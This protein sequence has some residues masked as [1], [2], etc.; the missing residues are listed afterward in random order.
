MVD[1]KFN[2]MSGCLSRKSKKAGKE[3]VKYLKK[4]FN[5]SV[6]IYSGI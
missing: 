3:K 5:N 4:S 1:K 2:Q 6:D